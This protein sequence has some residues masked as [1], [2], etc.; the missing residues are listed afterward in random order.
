MLTA[1][2]LHAK[3]Q[4]F[5]YTKINRDKS[6]PIVIRDKVKRLG[7]PFLFFTFSTLFLKYMLN[8]FMRRPVELS[9]EQVI[10]CFIYP[11]SNPLGEMWIV[12]TLFILS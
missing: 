4:L 5:Y 10:N 1:L 3:L 6:F 8:P 11:E 2:H 12:A 7:I 9:W